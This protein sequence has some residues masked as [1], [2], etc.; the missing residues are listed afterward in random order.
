MAG[1]KL[2]NN[3]LKFIGDT[4]ISPVG[5]VNIFGPI[6]INLSFIM[7]RQ[8]ES[9]L[10]NPDYSGLLSLVNHEWI[11]PMTEFHIQY[12]VFILAFV[13]Y[14]SEVVADIIKV[15]KKYSYN[16]LTE[17]IKDDN[18][19]LFCIISILGA[20]ILGLIFIISGS[21]V[22]P[23]NILSY[24]ENIEF[25]SHYTFPVH[26]PPI[27]NTITIGRIILSVVYYPLLVYLINY[28]LLP[29]LAQNNKNN[30]EGN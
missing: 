3:V 4:L 6:F 9:E 24:R 21:F 26:F 8:S 18:T 23:A 30:E 28:R 27:D 20:A 11:E 25:W 22:T 17:V 29:I 1:N 13:I 5:M 16:T 10:S 2:I 15:T 14:C 12:F 19:A 7:L